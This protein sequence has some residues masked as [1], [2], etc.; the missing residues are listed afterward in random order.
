M[1]HPVN[2]NFAAKSRVTE[3]VLKKCGKQEIL[4]CLVINTEQGTPNDEF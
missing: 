2:I 1:G 4:N 3:G